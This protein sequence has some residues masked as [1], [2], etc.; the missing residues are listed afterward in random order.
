M[1]VRGFSMG[2]RLG[3]NA[4]KNF[5]AIAIVDKNVII[6]YNIGINKNRGIVWKSNKEFDQRYS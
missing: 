5:I 3:A 4:P 1:D 6:I 2:S